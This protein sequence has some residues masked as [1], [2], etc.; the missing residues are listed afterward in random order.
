MAQAIVNVRMD[1]NL[2]C[3]FDQLCEELGL[4]MSAAITVFAKTFVR[5]QGMPFEVAIDPF[6]SESNQARLRETIADARTGKN[7]TEH[8]LIEVDDD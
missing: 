1:E 2:K 7:M 4:T 3:E 8:E 6:Y 5:R